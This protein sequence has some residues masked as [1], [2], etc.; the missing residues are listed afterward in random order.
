MYDGSA[1]TADS[2]ALEVRFSSHT[3]GNDSSASR[4]TFGHSTVARVVLRTLESVIS[5]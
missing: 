5:L 1:M 4:G 2:V 3:P